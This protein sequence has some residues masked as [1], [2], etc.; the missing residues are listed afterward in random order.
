MAK[1]YD[2][3][4]DAEGFVENFRAKEYPPPSETGKS[5]DSDIT[6]SQTVSGIRN[7]EMRNAKQSRIVRQ[8]RSSDS[9][10]IY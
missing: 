7:Y 4:F 5:E 10:K 1:R 8:K 2:N 3:D 9:K 6:K